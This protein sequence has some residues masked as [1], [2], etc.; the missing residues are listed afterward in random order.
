MSASVQPFIDDKTDSRA[1]REEGGETRRNDERNDFL[2]ISPRWCKNLMPANF[3]LVSLLR[4][5]FS[6]NSTNRRSRYSTRSFIVDAREMYV[7]A[8]ARAR[9]HPR[10]STTSS[11]S[12]HNELQVI[13]GRSLWKVPHRFPQEF[14][15]YLLCILFVPPFWTAAAAFNA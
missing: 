11:I 2:R 8:R 3:L 5:T 6:D 12:S 7:R 9:A 14:A 4:C 1:R 15:R 10:A 13:C